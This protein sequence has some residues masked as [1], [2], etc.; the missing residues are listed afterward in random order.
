MTNRF[1]H[2]R[3][4]QIT[5]HRLQMKDK[6]QRIGSIIFGAT[7]ILCQ[8]VVVYI[9]IAV[10]SLLFMQTFIEDTGSR[11]GANAYYLSLIPT[12]LYLFACM[13]WRKK[14]FKISTGQIIGEGTIAMIL[15]ILVWYYIGITLTADIGLVEPF[16]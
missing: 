4:N 11:N 8:L 15:F 1:C 16:F 13:I 2:P 12:L 14:S 7:T 3:L 10:V 6:I 5:N 9:I